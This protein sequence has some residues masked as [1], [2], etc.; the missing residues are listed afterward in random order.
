MPACPYRGWQRTIALSLPVLAPFPCRP[1]LPGLPV[2]D[3]MALVCQSRWSFLPEK[4]HMKWPAENLKRSLCDWK[5]Y[6]HQTISWAR[7]V[8]M[9]DVF[10][11]L[12]IPTLSS[13]GAWPIIGVAGYRYSGAR[14]QYLAGCVGVTGMPVRMGI[15]CFRGRHG[16]GSAFSCVQDSEGMMIFHEK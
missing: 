3:P 4:R 14:K 11:S 9:I 8:S 15:W 1:S 16:K 7:E 5:S 12:V 13:K 10:P 2:A 6:D